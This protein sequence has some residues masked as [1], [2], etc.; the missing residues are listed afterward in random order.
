MRLIIE[1]LPLTADN[2]HGPD[3]AVALDVF[4]GQ[5]FA[6]SVALDQSLEQAW[7]EIEERFKRNYLTPAQA[8]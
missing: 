3:A 4:K 6:L 5:K 8:S 7:N 2:A 1:V